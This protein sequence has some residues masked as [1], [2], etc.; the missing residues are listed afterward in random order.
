MN[1]IGIFTSQS[2]KNHLW[3]C[4][5]EHII[6]TLVKVRCYI[7]DILTEISKFGERAITMGNCEFVLDNLNT[8]LQWSFQVKRFLGKPE[9]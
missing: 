6:K 7:I 9:I 1:V 3:Y 2:K 5:R 4:I 8:R